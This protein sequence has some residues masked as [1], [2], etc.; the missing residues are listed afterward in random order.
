MDVKKYLQVANAEAKKSI[1]LRKL[2][3]DDPLLLDFFHKIEVVAE[4]FADLKEESTNLLKKYYEQL[5]KLEK[6][7]LY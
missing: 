5:N 4:P 7:R 2:P 3:R 6:A 1:R